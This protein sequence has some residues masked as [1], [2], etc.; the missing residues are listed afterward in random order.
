MEAVISVAQA[1]TE[2]EM[3]DAEKEATEQEM[4]GDVYH[5]EQMSTDTHYF[6]EYVIETLI[7]LT[8]GK[9]Y[10]NIWDVLEAM[11]QEC[12]KY[13]YTIDVLLDY[14]KEI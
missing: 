8:K 6:C 4:L 7:I 2:Q 10:I 11:K 5:E 13:D 9:Q 14:M 12:D 1:A 3:E